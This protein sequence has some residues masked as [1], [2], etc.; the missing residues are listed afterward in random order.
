MTAVTIPY[1]SLCLT[2]TP[3][4]IL[5]ILKILKKVQGIYG[6]VHPQGIVNKVR[7]SG[8]DEKWYGICEE[9]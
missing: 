6:L 2:V 7:F 1:G 9:E 4:D 3:G 5:P 8:C